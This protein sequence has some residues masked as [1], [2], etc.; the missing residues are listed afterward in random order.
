MHDFVRAEGRTNSRSSAARDASAAVA[1]A[2]PIGLS[3]RST[4][5]ARITR[6]A[7]AA[8]VGLRQRQSGAQLRNNTEQDVPEFGCRQFG[9]QVVRPKNDTHERRPTA[10]VECTNG[11]KDCREQNPH[12]WD[13]TPG[14]VWCE[15]VPV[16]T[17]AGSPRSWSSGRVARTCDSC[18]SG[19]D[20][21]RSAAANGRY[22]TSM[23]DGG[24]R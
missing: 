5:C 18:T 14:V 7:R 19:L 16:T 22:K 13:R 1:T 11:V 17:N 24:S 15:T 10:P 6:G 21:N 8:A 3:L 23:P 9:E 12:F 20:P 4:P 2:H